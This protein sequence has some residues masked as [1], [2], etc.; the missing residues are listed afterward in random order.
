MKSSTTPRNCFP[1]SQSAKDFLRTRY[2][3]HTMIYFRDLGSMRTMT[4]DMHECCS[5]LAVCE[6]KGHYTRSLKKS[7]PEWES[8][9]NLITRKMRSTANSTIRSTALKS[10]Q[11]MSC[12]HR[13]RTRIP[14]VSEGVT[15][16]ARRGK[17]ESTS[18]HSLGRDVTRPRR[19]RGIDTGLLISKTCYRKPG[20]HN[21]NFRSEHPTSKC[22]KRIAQHIAL[23]PG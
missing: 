14:T 9:S 8:K 7:Y 13:M 16:R 19:S 12:T 4:V 6:V 1:S 10:P 2:S 20:R 17:G 3:P 5:K 23:D 18:D 15:L 21:S 11:L 22:R